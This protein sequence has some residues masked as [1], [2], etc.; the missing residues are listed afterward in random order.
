MLEILFRD[1]HLLAVNKPAGLHVHPTGLSRGETTVLDLIRDQLGL[2]AHPVHRLDRATA[3]VLVLALTTAAAADLGRQWRDLQVEKTYQALVRGWVSAPFTQDTP[4]SDEDGPPR[5]AR[6]DFVPLKTFEAPW[7][8]NNF[9]TTRATL[10]Q[11]KPHTGRRHQIRLHLR[12]AGHPI[13]GDTTWGDL[14]LNQ[15]WRDHAHLE[16][17]QLACTALTFQHPATQQT[18]TLEAPLPVHLQSLINLLNQ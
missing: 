1:E 3:G 12:K 15:H 17:L 16:G 14:K 6:T 7:P 5:E 9:P 11:A 4:V 8:W 10:V 2:T 13:L 18:I